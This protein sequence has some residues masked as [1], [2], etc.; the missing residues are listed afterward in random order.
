M[1]LLFLILSA[2]LAGSIVPANIEQKAV[3]KW[4]V[5]VTDAPE[6]YQH[7]IVNIKKAGNQLKI[8]IRGGDADLKDQVL[9]VKDNILTGN[10]YVGEYVTLNI[11]ETKNGLAGT[12]Q[13]SSGKLALV[14]KKMEK[15]K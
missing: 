7:Y 14:F 13:T 12:A 8:D 15:T 1:Q 6:A 10:V 2:W 11:W 3:G 4:K 5:T 9:T